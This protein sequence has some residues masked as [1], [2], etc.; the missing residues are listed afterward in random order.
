M[1]RAL[2]DALQGHRHLRGE[3][4]FYEDDGREVRGY[5]LRGW[6]KAAQKRVG[7]RGDDRLIPRFPRKIVERDTGFESRQFRRAGFHARPFIFG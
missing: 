2:H 5:M 7:L 4:V 6:H 1:T 3:R